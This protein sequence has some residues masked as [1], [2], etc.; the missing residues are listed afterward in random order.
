MKHEQ[1]SEDAPRRGTL[2]QESRQ[3]RGVGDDDQ[4]HHRNAPA[5]SREIVVG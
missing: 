2:G 4:G 5:A 1:I 3:P